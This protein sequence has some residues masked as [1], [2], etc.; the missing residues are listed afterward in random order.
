MPNVTCRRCDHM[1]K[2]DDDGAYKF[3]AAAQRQCKSQCPDM[4][5]LLRCRFLENSV[6]PHLGKI[7]VA[8]GITPPSS[9]CDFRD[10]TKPRPDQN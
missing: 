9:L 5:S 2:V 6:A 8:P 10:R 4:D 1:V 7:E 3:G